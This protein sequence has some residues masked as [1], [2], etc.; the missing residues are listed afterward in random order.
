MASNGSAG[1]SDGEQSCHDV[2]GRRLAAAGLRRAPMQTYDAIIIGSGQA[3]P[4]LAKR[5]AGAVQRVAIIE[6]QSCG[7]TCINT[8]GTPT[9]TMVASA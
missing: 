3:G 4:S 5:L 7:E 8:G 9:K 6:R 1:G 2:V